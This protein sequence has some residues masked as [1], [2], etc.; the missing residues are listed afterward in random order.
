[1]F[2]GLGLVKMTYSVT[3]HTTT[4]IYKRVVAVVDDK[5]SN[6]T[7][8]IRRLSSVISQQGNRE[9]NKINVNSRY[10]QRD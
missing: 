9:G 4:R 3:C 8:N 7:M 10:I 1:M 6:R 5:C 2:N